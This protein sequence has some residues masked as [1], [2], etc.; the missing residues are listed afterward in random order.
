LQGKR[1]HH[2]NER[3]FPPKIFDSHHS[4]SWYIR[5]LNVSRN[6]PFFVLNSLCAGLLACV[7]PMRARGETPSTHAPLASLPRVVIV[8]DENATEAFKPRPEVVRAL[9]QRGITNFTGKADTGA[10]WHSLV[11]TQDVVGIKVFSTPG[12][13]VGTRS[14]VVAGIVEGLLAANIPTNHIII[15]DRQL[16]DLR[17][18]G[19]GELARQYGVRLAG[20]LDSGWDEKTFYESPLLGQLVF[21]DFEFQNKE[22]G[23]GRKSF[24]TKLLTTNVT[25]II[26]VSPLLNHNS[27]G[28]CGNLYSL[29]L[30]SVDNTIRFEGDPDKLAQAVPE[31]YAMP[32]LGDR[33]ALNIVDALICQY[34]GEHV[35]R[36]HDSVALNQLRFSTDPVALD[37]L[38]VQ[39]INAQRVRA[40]L[41]LA[42]RTNRL[43]L[44]R[45]ASLLEL[46]SADANRIELREVRKGE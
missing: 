18:A 45:N 3:H 24:V 39:E 23:V 19:F 20:S 6:A 22:E 40:A 4:G 8:E 17:Q 28:V 9:V 43:D 14:S 33:V 36:L 26:N 21:G 34:Q 46:G 1:S 16:S 44:Y 15:W 29:A 11:S 13:Q 32:A 25:K 30:G 7:V 38:S 27:V 42:S 35:S 12:P 31:I 10:A 2:E 41:A 37:V 5:A